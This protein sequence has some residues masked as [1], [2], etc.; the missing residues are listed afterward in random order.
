[1]AIFPRTPGLDVDG[2]NS[3]FAHPIFDGISN[4]LG[5]I[6]A[7]QVL[8]HSVTGDGGFQDGDRI[9]GTDL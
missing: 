8:R 7:S 2:L 1:M 3:I 4:K 9:D 6:I 5:P